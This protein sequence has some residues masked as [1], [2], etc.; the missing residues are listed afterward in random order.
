MKI[1]I[2]GGS[3][4]LPESKEYQ[5]AYDLG[6]ALGGGGHTILTGG[7]MGTM[8][9]SSRGAAESGAHVIGVTCDEI[10]NW[11]KKSHNP[12]GERRMETD[13]SA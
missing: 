12:M 4:P 10:E 8:E 11:R 6:A 5:F 13:N 7:Y 3:S 2:F 9:A 1:T